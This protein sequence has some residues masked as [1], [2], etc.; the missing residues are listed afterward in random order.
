M[1][2][3]APRFQQMGT[4][5]R[6]QIGFFAPF[7]GKGRRADFW[8][9]LFDGLGHRAEE[10][11]QSAQQ[12]IGARQ[13]PDAFANVE[14]LTDQ[15]II[16]EQRTFFTIKRG[17]ATVSLY[18]APFGNDLYISW[19]TFVL[20]KLSLTKI[21]LA[22]LLLAAP[23]LACGV[24]FLSMTM[25]SSAATAASRDPF[26]RGASDLVGALTPLL[27]LTLCC[28]GPLALISFF[29]L[30][31]AFR[32]VVYTTLTERDPL[33]IL[34]GDVSEFQQDDIIALEQA[35]HHTVLMTL[36]EI[37]IDTKILPAASFVGVR[38]RLI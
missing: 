16:V 32:T 15:G 14:V 38:R 9:N 4:G 37:G 11:F 20:P 19:D 21:A 10:V 34:R 8:A 2:T 31:S 36:D 18:I 12:K 13:I 3:Y 35:V 6:A 24:S 23:V 17:V 22:V 29:T 1:A 28:V 30:P 33:A 5:Q 25:L 27:C 7:A 26:G